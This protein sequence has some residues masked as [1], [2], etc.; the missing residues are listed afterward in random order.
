MFPPARPAAALAAI[1]LVQIGCQSR[2]SLP[3]TTSDP[4]RGPGLTLDT[5]KPEYDIVV[6]APT[7]GWVISLDRVAEQYRHHAVFVSLR[8]PNPG[9]LYPQVIVEQ[10]VATTVPTSRTIKVY[11]RILDPD[12]TRSS[13]PY[14]PAA[15]SESPGDPPAAPK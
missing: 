13:R 12:D 8:R 6:Q 5:S 1:L 15:R 3:D 2:P 9:F 7:P 11:A 14:S 4:Y 10:R